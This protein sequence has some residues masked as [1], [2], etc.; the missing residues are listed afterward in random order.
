LCAAQVPVQALRP[1][2]AWAS[3]A[4]VAEWRRGAF[5]GQRAQA[6]APGPQQVSVQVLGVLALELVQALGSALP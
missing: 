4:R 3:R 2:A 6:A 5:A 1:R